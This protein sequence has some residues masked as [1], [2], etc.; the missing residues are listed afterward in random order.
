MEQKTQRNIAELIVSRLSEWRYGGA[1]T[2][3]P[4]Q[5]FGIPEAAEKQEKT[6]WQSFLEGTPAKGWCDA[7]QAYLASIGSKK[8]GRRWLIA[9]IQSYGMSLGT[10][11]SIAMESYTTRRQACS[12][13]S[14][15]KKLKN[16][17]YWDQQV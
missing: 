17:T 13:L 3:S 9:L 1:T 12:N 5:A 16:N 7:Q 15:E 8:T 14:R 11:G 4:A 2:V 10:S 6:G